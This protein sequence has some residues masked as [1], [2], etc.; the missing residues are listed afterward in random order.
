MPPGQNVSGNVT[1]PGGGGNVTSPLG[2]SAQ[3]LVGALQSGEIIRLEEPA[4]GDPMG[5]VTSLPSASKRAEEEDELLRIDGIG[6]MLPGAAYS[7]G[8]SAAPPGVR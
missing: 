1:N 5:L 2:T 3:I 6:V 7:R 8:A 4:A